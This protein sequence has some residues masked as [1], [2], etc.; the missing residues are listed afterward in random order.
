MH[1]SMVTPA[2]G[3]NGHTSVA[4]MRGCSPVCFD[5]SISSEAFLIKQN[6]ASPTVSGGPTNVMTVRLVLLPG[7]TSNSLQP[8]T[9]STTEATA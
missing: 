9:V 6:A 5:M 2:T 1:S 4:P 3:T 7:S 8:S